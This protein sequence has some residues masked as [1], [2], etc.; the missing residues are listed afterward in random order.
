LVTWERGTWIT[1]AEIVA[2]AL[3][4]AGDGTVIALV[5]GLPVLAHLGYT[6]LTSL[7]L[8]AIPGPPV[9]AKQLRR[10]QDL[11]T[12]VVGFL[13]EMRRV[14]EFAQQGEVSGRPRS[15]VEKDLRWATQ[16]M[17]AAAAEVANVAGRLSA[18]DTPSGSRRDSPT[19]SHDAIIR[20][21]KSYRA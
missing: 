16:R 10:N 1:L 19:E 11:R 9:G 17:M 7:P 5:V 13:N 4:L 6:A 18:S 15:E 21:G 3:T 20:G 8:G 14:Q 12:R 2:L